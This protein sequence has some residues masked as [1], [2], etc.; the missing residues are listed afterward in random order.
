MEAERS[1]VEDL[2]YLEERLLRLD[3]RKSAQAVADLLADEFME[4]GSSG[5]IFDKQQI[6]AALQ[7]EL[8]IQRSLLDFK[9][10]VLAPG[11]VLTTYRAVRRTTEGQA[12]YTLVS[13]I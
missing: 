5:R 1:R 8:P 9:T 4:F 7:D 3:V 11:V 2:R 12:I 6:I 10:V 13:S